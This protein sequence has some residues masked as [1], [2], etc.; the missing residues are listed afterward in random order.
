MSSIFNPLGPQ[1]LSISAESVREYWVVC[2]M[3]SV[4]LPAVIALLVTSTVSGVVQL[5]TFI[6]IT[7]SLRVLMGETKKFVS[8]LRT[9]KSEKINLRYCIDKII[10]SNTFL[11]VNSYH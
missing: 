9:S 1:L 4:I 11:T 7:P 6:V 2:N 3:G 10:L 5:R 8:Q